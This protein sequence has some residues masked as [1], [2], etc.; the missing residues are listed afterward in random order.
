MQKLL[1]EGKTE[2]LKGFVSKKTGRK[3]EAFLVLKEGKVSFEFAPRAAK[4]KAAREKKAAAPAVKL[5]FTTLPEIGSC[6]L[7][8][9]RVFE[10]PETYVCE[11]SQREQRP[12]KF[13]AGRVILEQPLDR[14]QAVKLLKEG[15]TDLLERFVSRKTGK[16]F[17]AHLVLGEK[18]KVG[19]EFPER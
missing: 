4:P 3:F 6:P 1:T 13:H 9:G 17:A 19:F 5:D 7:C 16:N 14:D 15:R 8:K 12:C 2:L 18:G 11:N 10:G